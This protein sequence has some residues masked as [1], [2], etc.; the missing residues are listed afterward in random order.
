MSTFPTLPE[1][2]DGQAGF[3][4]RLAP[5][6][7]DRVQARVTERLTEAGLAAILTDDPEDVAYLTGFF[8]HPCERPVAVWLQADGRCVL[9]LPELEHEHA[10]LQQARAEFAVFGEYPGIRPP[11][12]ALANAVGPLPAAT[13]V[14]FGSQISH[15]RLTAAQE[16]IG[17]AD[18]QPTTLITKARYRKFDEEIA[19]HQE[20]ARI[21]DLMIT[22][23]VSLMFPSIAFWVVLLKKAASS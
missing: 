14:G 2:V 17:P 16:A 11:F 10:E 1:P 22:G 13:P 7:F 15:A 19:M 23:G 21:T 3:N 12:A 8:H 20:A 9:L 6:F 5:E 4:Q 18:W